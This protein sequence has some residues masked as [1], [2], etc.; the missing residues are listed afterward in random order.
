MDLLKNL[1]LTP[2][3]FPKPCIV[4]ISVG[5]RT[6]SIGTWALLF[7]AITA[8]P[9][10]PSRRAAGTSGK[11]KGRAESANHALSFHFPLVPAARRDGDDGRAVIAVN[12]NA[13]VAIQTVR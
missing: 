8:R 2:F 3:S 11:W 9:S 4:T 7:T 10:S 5:T 6:V 1:D 13:H 12:R